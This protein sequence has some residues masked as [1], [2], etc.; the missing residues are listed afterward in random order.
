ML[1]TCHSA[2]IQDTVLGTS[3]KS[4]TVQRR[5][6]PA[7]TIHHI[8]TTTTATGAE[9]QFPTVKTLETTKQRKQ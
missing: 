9:N 3:N 4:S 6:R 1:T 8:T 7:C 2:I 5:R